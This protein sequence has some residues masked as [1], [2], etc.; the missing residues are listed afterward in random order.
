VLAGLLV[1]AVFLLGLGWG[2]DPYY[3]N[4][5]INVGADLIGAIVT[6]FVIMPI[7][8]RASEG[9]VREHPRLDYAWYVDRVADAT[10]AVRV[11]D[12]Y[13]NLL[14]GPHTP[15]FFQAVELALERQSIVQILLLD[16]NSPAARQRAHELDDPDV[17]R[18]IMRNLRALN[19]FRNTIQPVS[20]SRNFNVRIYTASPSI[21]VYRWDDK[22]LVSFFPVGKI[23][24]QG[25]Q[26]EVVVD[27]PL[28]KFVNERFNSLWTVSKDLEKFMRLP[29]TLADANVTGTRL[30]V[31]F[32]QLDGRF[33][34]GD[35]RIMAQMARRR[36]E[37]TLVYSD[38]DQQVLNE[39]AII[40][41]TQSE[42]FTTLSD[43]F[44]EKYGHSE[45]FFI[46]L[47][48]VGKDKWGRLLT[49]TG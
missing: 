16:P 30:E 48:P 36:P 28:G 42:L 43:Q 29:V 8:S 1:V 2:I 22:A 45:E 19:D 10:S 9:R 37:A 27:S 11:M 12:T 41:D 40:D 35:S 18:E 49:K 5:A 32:I 20:L 14:D 21:A 3:P 46:R 47:E 13:S 23:S 7:V 4:V 38:C 39:L 26:L 31:E 25:V 17:Y 24:S 34:V 44:E 6:I 33:Y 15:H